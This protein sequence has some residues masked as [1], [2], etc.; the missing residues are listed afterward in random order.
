MDVYHHFTREEIKKTVTCSSLIGI[1]KQAPADASL[2]QYLS[3]HTRRD[4]LEK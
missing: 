2:G 3:K 1:K 4:V